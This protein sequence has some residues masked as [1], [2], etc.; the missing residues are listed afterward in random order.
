MTVSI[1]LCEPQPVTRIGL[2]SLLSAVPSARVAG[3]AETCEQAV[4]LSH[5]LRPD[6]V[7][8]DMDLPGDGPV[9][10]TRQIVHQETANESAVIIL[11]PE[12]DERIVETL[13]AGASG[14]LLRSS[15]AEE[16]LH[17]V[18]VILQGHGYLAPP[19]VRHVLEHLDPRPSTSA[20]QSIY[21][22]LTKREREVLLLL[23]E[24]L[25]NTEISGRLFVG[26]PTVKY[27]ISQMLRK[28]GLRDR[29]QAVAFAYRNGLHLHEREF[30]GP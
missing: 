3:E 13:Q 27:H 18:E 16:F 6:I 4:R 8:A 15:A 19:V 12:R 5:S 22:H 29:L 7:V 2:H 1:L 25:S 11:A 24:G 21:S 17:A 30:P 23:T 14:I 20:G 26:E 10:L 9:E 28:L